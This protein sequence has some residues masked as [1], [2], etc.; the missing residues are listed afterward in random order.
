MAEAYLHRCEVVFPYRN[1]LGHH[2]LD[3]KNMHSMVHGGND[4]ENWG[5]L[6]NISREAPEI[7]H[8][9]VDIGTERKYQPRRLIE[10]HLDGA[11]QAQGS[12]CFAV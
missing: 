4:I 10:I 11:L 3:N 5:D 6:I 8:K 12:C 9:K 7:A 1:K 2:I